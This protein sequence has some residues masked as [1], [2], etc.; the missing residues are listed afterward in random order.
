MICHFKINRIWYRTELI[1]VNFYL[2]G[3]KY[4]MTLL[5]KK[6]ARFLN[7]YEMI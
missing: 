4:E 7:G 6:F 1:I 2:F 3:K 5:S